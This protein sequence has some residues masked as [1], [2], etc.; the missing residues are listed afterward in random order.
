[1]RAVARVAGVALGLVSCYYED[2]ASMI[3][4][5]LHPREEDG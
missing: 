1:M 3:S 4:A 2:K 5:A